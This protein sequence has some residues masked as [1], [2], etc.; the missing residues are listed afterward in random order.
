MTTKLKISKKQQVKELSSELSKM[1]KLK[2]MQDDEISLLKKKMEALRQKTQLLQELKV[3]Q[4]SVLSGPVFEEVER[5]QREFE[6]LAAK[7]ITVGDYERVSR[8]DGVEGPLWFKLNFKMVD[9]SGFV[10]N[11][12]RDNAINKLLQVPENKVTHPRVLKSAGV[13]RL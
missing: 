11:D 2:Q 4:D 7:Y 3:K 5:M 9:P 10:D 13:L 1:R 8:F 6:G 12:T